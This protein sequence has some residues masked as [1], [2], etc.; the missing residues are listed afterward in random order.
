MFGGDKSN[1]SRVTTV[2]NKTTSGKALD[3]QCPLCNYKLILGYY[4]KNIVTVTKKPKFRQQNVPFIVFTAKV[5]IP[6][7]RQS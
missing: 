5:S 3:K 2:T 1:V 6:N 4:C 7:F